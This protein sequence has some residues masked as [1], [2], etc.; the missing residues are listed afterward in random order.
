MS[1]EMK[2][3]SNKEYHESDGM[4]KSKLFRIAKS[5]EWFKYCEENP[6][7]RTADMT[8]GSAFHTLVLEPDK[9]D[10]E[11]A[12]C[13]ECDRRTKD[14][15]SI[16][17]NF[18]YEAKGKEIIT[19][20]QF[21][22]ICEMRD[23]LAQNKIAMALLSGQIENSFYWIDELT[24]ELCKCRPDAIPALKSERLIIDLKSCRNAD[25]ETF[26]KDSIKLGYD[27]Q[28]AMY[29][30]GVDKITGTP[31][32]FIFVAVEKTPPYSVNILQ[33]DNLFLRRGQELFREL[34]GIYSECRKSGNWYGYNG[35]SGYINTL[36]L[37]RW[38]MSEY[39]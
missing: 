20:D 29:K 2:I 18:V 19:K 39:E 27:L 25:T 21:I 24:G 26:L 31:H 32:G 17:A 7:E 15:K 8:M 34:I 38:L 23:K 1:N 6:P 16:Y 37:P 36:S 13:P 30:E 5:P 22:T 12:V 11:Y 14:G 4:S 28:A 33:A 9:F 3:I 10:D 35:F